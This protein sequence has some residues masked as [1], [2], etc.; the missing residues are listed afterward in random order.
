[1]GPVAGMIRPGEPFS[2]K[3]WA[4]WFKKKKTSQ[5]GQ[6]SHQIFTLHLVGKNL[7]PGTLGGEVEGT[8]VGKKGGSNHWWGSAPSLQKKTRTLSP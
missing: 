1:V 4:D 6:P 3:S 8:G 5:R 2:K 7:I